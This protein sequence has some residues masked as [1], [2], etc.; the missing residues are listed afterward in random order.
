M[1]LFFMDQLITAAEIAEFKEHLIDSRF[2]DIETPRLMQFNYSSADF[3]ALG[4]SCGSRGVP[5]V[6]IGRNG[7]TSSV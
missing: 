1:G 4:V 6:F 5:A 2:L 3:T 7:H